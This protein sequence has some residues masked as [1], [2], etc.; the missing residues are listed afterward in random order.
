MGDAAEEPPP[1]DAPVEEEETVPGEDDV[2]GPATGFVA[3]PQLED[4]SIK[5]AFDAFADT[6]TSTVDTEKVVDVVRYLNLAVPENLPK[7]ILS[8]SDGNPSLTF[9][10]VKSL[11]GLIFGKGPLLETSPKQKQVGTRR[12]YLENGNLT[13]DEAVLSFM[14]AL[15][16]H[17][18]KCEKDGKYKE[19]RTAAKRLADLKMHEEQKHKR[20]MLARHEQEQADAQRAFAMEQEQH[21]MMWDLKMQDYE[22]SVREQ[23]ARYKQLHLEKLDKFFAEADVKKPKAAR[24]SKQ[25][26]NQRQIMQTLAKQGKYEEAEAV[27][28]LADKMEKAEM[29]ATQGTYEAEVALKEQQLRSK[30]QQ[31][32]EG[33]LHRAGRGRD[34]L[35][36]T[37]QLDLERRQQRFKNVTAEL[38]NLQRL[39][40]IQ[41]NHFLDQQTLA[42]KRQVGAGRIGQKAK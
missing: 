13:E 30:Q 28:K 1:A 14:R 31:E 9:A 29:D 37:R 4:A 25:L 17:K 12:N 8:V 21:R 19:A 38:H 41:L 11:C 15:E 7:L 3:Q 27:K 40:S 6:E 16:E 2:G 24:S 34:E 42:G 18:K 26:L 10:A 35:R 20:D 32:T 23:L 5:E 39:E 36:L 22:D 33:L